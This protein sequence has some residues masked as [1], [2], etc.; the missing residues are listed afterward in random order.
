MDLELTSIPIMTLF[1][2]E[3]TFIIWKYHPVKIKIKI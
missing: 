2:I 1:E 3:M